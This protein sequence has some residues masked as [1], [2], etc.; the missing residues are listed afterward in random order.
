MAGHAVD[1]NTISSLSKTYKRSTTKM[2][3]TYTKKVPEYRWMDNVPDE[4]IIP[5]GRE[6]LVP[7]DTRQGYGAAQ[8]TDGGYEARTESP[9][10]TEGSFTFNHTNARFLITRRA[11]ALDKAA[12]GN[13][14]IR[15]IKW[16]SIKCIESVMRKYGFMFYG[17]STGVVAK[18]SGDPG[19]SAASHTITLKDAFGITSLDNAAYLASMFVV[20]EGIALI[21]SA[22]LLSNAIGE[23]TA[24][25]ASAGTIDV[26]WVPGS[27][28]PA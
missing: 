3:R 14:I 8:I 4:D 24:V 26:T 15:Q 16:Q 10:P 11:Q 5:S 2:Y 21:R 23:V 28:D 18:V 25:S 13:W 17:F 22:A 20:G 7:M 27:V 6:N 12:R 19:G 9:A 1:I